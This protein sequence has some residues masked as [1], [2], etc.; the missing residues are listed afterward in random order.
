MKVKNCVWCVVCG[1]WCGC[2]DRWRWRI[3]IGEMK[4][5]EQTGEGRGGCFVL[6]TKLM[7]LDLVFS[8]FAVFEG[9]NGGFLFIA[10]VP[11]SPCNE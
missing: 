5:E 6:L 9:L 7:G 2:E 4:G 8:S 1:V 3:E 10:L 11:T